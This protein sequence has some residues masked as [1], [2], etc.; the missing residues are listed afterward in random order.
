[1]QMEEI[2]DTLPEDASLSVSTFLLAHVADRDEIYEVRYHENAPD[3]DYV[4]LDVRFDACEATRRAYDRHG[5]TL[6]AEY[7]GL[8]VILQRPADAAQES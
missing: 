8:I 6:F 2:L 4:V 3:V 1:M 7:D 5:Y